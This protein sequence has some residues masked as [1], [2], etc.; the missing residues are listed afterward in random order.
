MS[1]IILLSRALGAAMRTRAAALDAFPQAQAGARQPSLSHM[2]PPLP[3]A[4]PQRV[5]TLADYGSR[6]ARR[7]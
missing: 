6:Q 3:G 2:R 5:R 4:V 7:H 1:R